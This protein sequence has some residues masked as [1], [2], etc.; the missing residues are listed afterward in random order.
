MTTTIEFEDREL[1]WLITF[2]KMNLS[3]IEE[4]INEK[5]DMNERRYL[6]SH[7]VRARTMIEK[8][9]KSNKMR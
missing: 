9:G 1:A 2:V 7:I 4:I 3:S 8:L 5:T 6:A